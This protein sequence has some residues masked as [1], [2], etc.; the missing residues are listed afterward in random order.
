[1][2]CANSFRSA[3]G[4]PVSTLLASVSSV[5]DAEAVA[6]VVDVVDLKDPARGALGMLDAGRVRDIV[7]VCHGRHVVSAALG[8]A[9]LS[10]HALAEACATMDESGVDFVKLGVHDEEAKATIDALAA[11]APRARRVGVLFA[12]RDPD[13]ALLNHL[14]C[15]G[16]AGAMLDTSDKRH[17]SL[18][19]VL[20]PD[21]IVDFLARVHGFGMF[22]GLAGSL[23]PEH[24]PRV[25]AWAPD[26]VGVRGAICEGN[27]RTGR[28]SRDKTLA[29]AGRFD[30]RKRRS[31]LE[32]IAH[33]ASAT[34]FLDVEEAAT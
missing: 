24:L 19:D 30:P 29:L 16:F 4:G 12:D 9:P 33:R 17:G 34:S 25:L 14:A 21:R 20:A 32:R 5:E 11:C 2:P 22:A 6:G 3:A 10:A 8:E 27:A 1:M 23:Q 28:V 18:L 7:R 13:F 26:F 15:A 31:T